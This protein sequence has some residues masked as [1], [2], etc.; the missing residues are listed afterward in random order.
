MRTSRVSDLGN[1]ANSRAA[2]RRLHTTLQVARAAALRVL[3]RPQLRPWALAICAMVPLVSHATIVTTNE[4]VM[5]QIYS[6]TSFGT[7]SIDIRFHPAHVI[8]DPTLLHIDSDTKLTEL[9]GRDPSPMDN[10]INV[11]FVDDITFCG[12]ASHVVIGCG[13]I[14]GKDFAV[15]ASFAAGVM[16]GDLL[17][18]E[19]GHNLGLPHVGADAPNLMN[20]ILTG[21]RTLTFEQVAQIMTSPWVQLDGTQRFVA[22]TPFAVV[23]EP[24]ATLV[25]ACGVLLLLARVSKRE[26][27]RKFFLASQAGN[28]AHPA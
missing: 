24:R 17:S 21:N 1:T 23:P 12:G 11:F 3:Q 16:G 27:G 2:R 15:D 25:L 9:F 5:D 7:Q 6:Q 18:H 4:A 19:L 10:Q 22:I 26:R 14:G 20:A 13:L 28:N 8:S